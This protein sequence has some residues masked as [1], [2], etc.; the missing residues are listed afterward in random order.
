MRIAFLF[1]FA[2]AA[3]QDPAPD[4]AMELKTL[5]DACKAA[6]DEF[7]RPFR[8]RLKTRKEGEELPEPDWS[9]HPA[10]EYVPKYRALAER[11]KGGDVALR[12]M[13]QVLRLQCRSQQREASG[14]TVQETLK[15]FAGSETLDE[16]LREMRTNAWFIG[17]DKCTTVF[18]SVAK[19]SP[20]AKVR[21]TALF[22]LGD[23]LLNDRNAT[24]D[25]VAEGRALMERI[26]K[27][28]ADSPFAAKAKPYLFEL[29]RLQV[30]MVAPDFETVDETGK[31]WKLSDYRGKITVVDFWGYW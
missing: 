11:A 3:V 26:L 12:A 15:A 9:K 20:H 22:Y 25:Q 21:A 29:D 5:N 19:D 17:R 28:Y 6:E 10:A 24:A 30:G 16:L 14:S 4:P 23:W 2:L 31:A 18:T 7:F 13:I 8:E 1:A 27:D